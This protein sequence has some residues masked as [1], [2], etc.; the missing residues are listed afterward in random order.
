MAMMMF[1]NPAPITAT[2]AM[3]MIKSGIHMMTSVMRMITMST[4]RP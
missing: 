3:M 4:T 1:I 2:S